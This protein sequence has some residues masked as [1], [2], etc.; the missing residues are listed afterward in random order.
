MQAMTTLWRICRVTTLLAFV[1]TWASCGDVFRPVAIPLTP[2]PPNPA[3]FHFVL[4]LS[5]NGT[6]NAG[7]V[8]RIDVSGD[9]NVGTQ[10]VGLAPVHAAVLPNGSRVYVANQLE[11]TVSS[12]PLGASGSI[13]TT[14]LPTGSHPVFVVADSSTAYVANSATASVAAIS[15][16]TNA[17]TNLISVG[18]NPVALAELPNATKVYAVNQADGTVTSISAVNKAPIA[19]LSVGASPVWAVA[20]SDNNRVYVLSSGAGT[21]TTVDPGTDTVLNSVPVGAGANFLLYDAKLNRLYVTNPTANTVTV[22]NAL[23]DP[24]SAVFTLPVAAG[25]VSVAVLPDGSRFYVASQSATPQVTVFNASD[26]SFKAAIPLS[27]PSAACSGLTNP[28]LGLFATAAAGSSRVYVANCGAGSTAIIRTVAET[29]SGG[30]LQPDTLVLEMAAPFSSG[31]PGTPG[32]N[33]P[34]QNPVFVLAG[35]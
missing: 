10:T 1:L 28:A 6:D 7:A 18:Q 23:T 16:A 20:R 25:P 31:N 2:T 19:T 4:I 22:L 3:A 8:S 11:D 30:T 26:G 14:S 27:P 24:P 15:T 9:T 32:G 17:V 13:A 34:P 21:V 33:P 5:D 12:V 29:S 35:P